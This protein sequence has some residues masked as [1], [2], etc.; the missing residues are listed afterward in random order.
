MK[1]II[2]HQPE[3]GYRYSMD[4]VVL[5][6]HVTPFAG[7]KI[8]DIG[9]GSGIMPLILGSRFADVQIIGIEIQ[10]QLAGFAMQNTDEN[11]LSGRIRIL[12]KDIRITTAFDTLGPADI[13]ISNPPYI[14]KN[15]GRLNPNLQKAIAR[16]ELE[17]ELADFFSSAHRLL[18]PGGQILFIFPAERL[19]DIFLA[20]QPLDFQLNWLR[21]I[22]TRQKNNAEL[23]I[24]SGLKQGHGPCV[25][26]PPLVV[27]DN[28]NNPTNEYAAMFKP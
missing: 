10:P 7:C 22:H 2:T 4:P 18:K 25:I 17:L 9:C 23:V 12:N 6:A 11:H 15:A 20:M 26:R 24:V 21:F 19:T 1:K 13:V 3:T 28:E 27:Y 14:K 8:I 16:H 5:A